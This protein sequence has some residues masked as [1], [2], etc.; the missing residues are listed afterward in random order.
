MPSAWGRICKCGHMASAVGIRRIPGPGA[1]RVITLNYWVWQVE[2]GKAWFWKHCWNYKALI[3][4]L[5][6]PLT[7]NECPWGGRLISVRLCLSFH[8]EKYENHISEAAYRS[9]FKEPTVILKGLGLQWILH[10]Y[11]ALHPLALQKIEETWEKS[12]QITTA[13]ECTSVTSVIG[14]EINFAEPK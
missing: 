14:E 4:L 3:R 2:E 13:K 6:H 7:S 12:P 8:I 9:S 5:D 10:L 1:S 11:T